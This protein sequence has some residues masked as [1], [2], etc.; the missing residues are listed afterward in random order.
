M[1]KDVLLTISGLQFNASE[2]K[3][4]AADEPIEVVTPASYFEADG[5]H[6]ILYDEMEEGMADITKNEITISP[7]SVAVTKT[8]L[9]NAIITFEEKRKTTTVYETPYGR[10]MLGIT[11]GKI[12]R[13]ETEDHLHVTLDYLLDVNYQPLAACTL[14]LDVTPKSHGEKILSPQSLKYPK[15]I[16]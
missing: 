10:F 12:N 4:G 3:E 14:N 9:I 8:G 15:T 1:T 16:Q 5:T 7:D 11:S 2:E 13:S 6:H